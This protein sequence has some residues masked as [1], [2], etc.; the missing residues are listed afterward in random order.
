MTTFSHPSPASSHPVEPDAVLTDLVLEAGSHPAVQHP[1]LAACA[2]GTWS[3]PGQ[4]LRLFVREYT[5]YVAWLPHCLWRVL[6]RLPHSLSRDVWLR[7]FAIERGQYDAAD[8]EVLRRVGLEPHRLQGRSLATAWET[9]AR[10]VGV[11]EAELAEPTPA[12]VAWR[13][14]LLQFLS[15]ASPT[16]VVGAWALGTEQ[17]ARSIS[18]QLLR[19]ILVE[20]RLRRDSFACL[21]LQCLAD[22]QLPEVRAA[23]ASLATSGDAIDELRHGML[24]ALHLRGEFFDHLHVQALAAERQL[25]G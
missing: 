20:G 7:R 25:T 6:A 1:F 5:G 9:F 3:D 10:A 2:R 23:V 17:V 8:C 15:E 21:E 12:A 13:T 18:K 24:T 19:G 4:A 14:R 22:R 11:T 16:E